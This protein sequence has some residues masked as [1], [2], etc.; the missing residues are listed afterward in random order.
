MRRESGKLQMKVVYPVMLKLS[1]SMGIM[2]LVYQRIFFFCVVK[3]NKTDKR[4]M[5]YYNINQPRNLIYSYI[6]V[7][8]YPRSD[9]QPPPPNLRMSVAARRTEHRVL[10][11]SKGDLL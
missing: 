9:I 11:F 8:I 2:S 3:F 6:Y 7:I 1:F 5:V 10:K 4:N